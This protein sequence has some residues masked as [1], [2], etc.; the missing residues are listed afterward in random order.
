MKLKK[1]TK[2]KGVWFYGLSGS[3]KTYSSK[4]LKLKK[5]K[6]IIVDGDKVRKLI[7][8]DLGF[9]LKDRKIQ[10]TRV[11]GIAKIIIDSGFFPILST[12]YFNKKTLNLCKKNKILPILI[13][14]LNFDKILINH[15]TYKNKKNVVGID[16]KYPK[17]K[18]LIV[19]NNNEKN[20]LFKNN[21]LKKIKFFN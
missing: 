7:S 19:I 3:G 15:K 11:F 2:Y 20:Y 1:N 21:F 8:C 9:D 6:S 10:L 16:L 17:I 18:T 13:Q 5:K 4:L 14:R 12:V